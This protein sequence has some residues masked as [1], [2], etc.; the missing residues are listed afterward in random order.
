M[1]KR[2]HTGDKRASIKNIQS[3]IKYIETQQFDWHLNE[4]S[5]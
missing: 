3:T 1:L 5:R 4:K 2:S